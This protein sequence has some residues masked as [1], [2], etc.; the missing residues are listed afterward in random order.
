VLLF[1]WPRGIVR[2]VA[3]QGEDQENNDVHIIDFLAK[4]SYE[5]NN[6]TRK[7]VMRTTIC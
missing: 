3:H 6:S 2:I 1:S 7:K 4:K 5:D